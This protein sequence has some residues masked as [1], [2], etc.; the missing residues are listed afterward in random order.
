MAWSGKKP[1][2]NPPGPLFS[3]LQVAT[4]VSKSK[5]TAS[6][7]TIQELLRTQLPS[8]TSDSRFVL[9]TFVPDDLLQLVIARSP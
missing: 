5:V 1:L 4:D 7:G 6:L 8:S 9:E 3:A 2:P